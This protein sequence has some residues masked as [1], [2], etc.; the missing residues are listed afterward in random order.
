MYTHML[1]END[2]PAQVITVPENYA[3]QFDA[4]HGDIIILVMEPRETQDMI[5]TCEDMGGELI[6]NPYTIIWTCEKVDF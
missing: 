6:Y 5:N 3:H 4:R 1:I 2:R